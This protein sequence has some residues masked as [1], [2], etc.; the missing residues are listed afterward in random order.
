VKT[1]EV[2]HTRLQEQ[3]AKLNNRWCNVWKDCGFEPLNPPEM[4]SWMES[5]K[6]ILSEQDKI[7]ICAREIEHLKADLVESRDLLTHEL[8]QVGQNIAE[9]KEQPLDLLLE[10]A[11]TIKSN[12]KEKITRLDEIQKQVLATKKEHDNAKK[13]WDKVTEEKQEWVRI[14]QGALEKAGFS[15][16]SSQEDI[17]F[18]LSNIKEIKEAG[19]EISTLRITRI[20]SMERNIKKFHEDITK[21]SGELGLGQ[22][23][24]DDKETAHSLAHRLDEERKKYTRKETLEKQIN[25]LQ[26]KNTKQKEERETAL[27]QLNP[28][29]QTAEQR[30]QM[31]FLF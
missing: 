4:L 5:R 16:A 25:D 8:A 6:T 3:Q 1:Q 18:Y 14:W 11:E 13:K 27:A 28:L 31:S 17:S 23:S 29:C 2:K 10:C 15:S 7:I 21:L 26:E 22:G 20:Q 24:T 12:L 30:K 9:T 19:Q